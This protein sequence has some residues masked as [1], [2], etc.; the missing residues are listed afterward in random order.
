MGIAYQLSFE[1]VAGA[2]IIKLFTS[3]KSLA[4]GR[5]G[6][7][8]PQASCSVGVVQAICCSSDSSGNVPVLEHFAL[9]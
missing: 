3:T 2:H 1:E 6:S 4:G 5:T 7:A 8:Q 9:I